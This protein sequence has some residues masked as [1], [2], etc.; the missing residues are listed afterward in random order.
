MRAPKRRELGRYLVADP[1]ICH[2]QLTF[3]GARILVKSVLYYCRARQGLGLDH[4]RMF[5][6]SQP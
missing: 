4:N 3:K 6:Q 5:R 2:G 1:E